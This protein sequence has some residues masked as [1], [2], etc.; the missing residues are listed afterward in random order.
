MLGQI[1]IVREQQ[2]T[3]TFIVQTTDIMQRLQ[4]RRQEIVNGRAIFGIV[5]R[6]QVAWWLVQENGCG[7]SGA[8]DFSIADHEIR[9]GD[10]GGEFQNTLSVDLHLPFIDQFL[11]GT[12]ASQSA[13]GK[14]SVY[15]HGF[16]RNQKEGDESKKSGKQR[17]ND[18]AERCCHRSAGLQNKLI[19]RSRKLYFTVLGGSL[20]GRWRFGLLSIDHAFS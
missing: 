17:K 18:P 12:T 1:P 8:N 16:H 5:L 9:F 11:A 10:R 3:F 4:R 13:T 20:A 7:S 14:E 2:Q 19:G 15:S 6:A